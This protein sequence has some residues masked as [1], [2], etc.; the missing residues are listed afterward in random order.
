MLLRGQV[1]GGSLGTG[2]RDLLRS[3]YMRGVG[4]G[5]GGF[6][7]TTENCPNVQ[8]TL[9]VAAAGTTKIYARSMFLKLLKI[10]PYFDQN[11]SKIS[12]NFLK[13]IIG[14]NDFLNICVKI[15]SVEFS[16]LGFKQFYSMLNKGFGCPGLK[17]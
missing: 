3:L 10:N 4:G 6:T 15:I 8:H 14:L 16:T 12:F 5:R 9:V 13:I 2:K 11:T 1:K 17:F 7:H